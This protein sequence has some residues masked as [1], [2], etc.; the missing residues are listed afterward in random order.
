[1]PGTGDRLTLRTATSTGIRSLSLSIVV[2]GVGACRQ[3]EGKQQDSG[4]PAGSVRFFICPYRVCEWFSRLRLKDSIEHSNGFPE[5]VPGELVLEHRIRVVDL[6]TREGQLR[7]Q[8]VE[9]GVRTF[10]VHDGRQ[11]QGLGPQFYGL[12]AE[13]CF[14]SASWYV[15]TATSTSADTIHKP[16]FV[17]KNTPVIQLCFLGFF[18]GLEAHK[19]GDLKGDCR[20]EPFAEI[21]PGKP[22]SSRMPRYDRSVWKT[23]VGQYPLRATVI[24]LSAMAFRSPII[25]CS[26]RCSSAIAWSSD[27]RSSGYSSGAY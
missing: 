23:S 2:V 17:L 24:E 27:K 4:G 10:G 22:R 13:R 21:R 18:H 15:F 16:P 20:C 19:D 14:S 7:V 6:G 5:P 11:A 26:S 1:M 3:G 9:L 12:R 25:F 8:H